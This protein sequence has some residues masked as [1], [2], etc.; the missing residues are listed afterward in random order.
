M[1]NYPQSFNPVSAF[2][3]ALKHYADFEGRARRQEFWMFALA[4]A[5]IGVIF[6]ILMTI[7]GTAVLT[8]AITD[9]MNSGEPMDPMALFGGFGIMGT[10]YNIICLALAIPS[11]A[12]GARRMHDIGKSGWWQLIAYV[13]CVGWII[14]LVF[15]C[16]DSEPDNQ[17]GPNPKS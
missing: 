8:D 14:F 3:Y 6:T 1:E 7:T 16:K 4:N 11:F 15:A 10:I 5:I 2:V 13:P 17:Y 9:A 12:V